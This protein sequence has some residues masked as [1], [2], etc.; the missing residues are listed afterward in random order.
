MDSHAQLEIRSYANVIG[1]IVKLW[2]PLAWAAFEDYN[3][4]RGA[5]LLSARDRRIVEWMATDPSPAMDGETFIVIETW[6]W[7]EH[8][9]DGKLKPNRERSECEAKLQ[10]LGITAPWVSRPENF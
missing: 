2:C 1:E 5:L 4:R 7:M 6:G 9:K 8:G 3:L 10:S